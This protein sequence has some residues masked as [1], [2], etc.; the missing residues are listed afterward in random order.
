MSRAICIADEVETSV[1]RRSGPGDT[2][3]R[4]LRRLLGMDHPAP[5]PDPR[6]STT[7]QT[8]RQAAP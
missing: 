8:R 7:H 4:L 2:S 1:Y 3:T 6:M 5:T